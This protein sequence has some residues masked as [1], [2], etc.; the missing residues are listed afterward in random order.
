MSK[1]ALIAV[2]VFVALLVLVL[3][4]REDRVAVGIRTLA[5]PALSTDAV[6]GI[7]LGGKKSAL[8]EKNDGAWTVAD[9]SAPQDRFAAEASVVEQALAALGELSAGNFVTARKAKHEELELT[10]ELGLVLTVRQQ[11]SQPLSLVLGRAAKGGGNYLRLAGADEVFVGQGRFGSLADKDVTAWRKRKL[12]EVEAKDFTSFTV[13]PPGAAPFTAARGGE[14][15]AAWRLVDGEAPDGFR[16]DDAALVRAA[17]SL[18]GMRAADYATKDVSAEAAGLAGAAPEGGQLSARAEDGRALAVRFGKRDD[19]G[20]VFAQLEGDP[21]I[22]LVGGHVADSLMRA[23]PELRDLTLAR[24][25]PADVTRFVLEAKGERVVVEQQEGAWVLT[26][27]APAGFD[28]DDDGM[29]GRLSALSRLKGQR[30]LDRA[31]AGAGLELPAALITLTLQD[32][33]DKRIAFGA[34]A[35]PAAGGEA[36]EAYA[37]G[38]EEDNV[39]LVPKW[40]RARYEK[41]FELLKKPPAPQAPGPD[42]MPPG[43]GRPGGMQGLDQ[44]P[45]EVRKQLEEAMRQQGMGGR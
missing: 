26:T 40:Q 18:A 13:S 7:E 24:F 10:P 23:L 37:R 20:R 33:S 11:G 14:A 31:P 35:P 45:P 1:N 22:Y 38:A 15:G 44:L 25:E 9:P 4:T 29:V 2:G 34:D 28:F 39:Y 17:S 36:T 12:V 19:S 3:V 27:P 32:G 6:T 30:R 21:Q 8:L 16:L 43:M 42:G 41:P 5:L